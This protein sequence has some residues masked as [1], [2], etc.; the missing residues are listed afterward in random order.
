MYQ[1]KETNVATSAKGP[2]R[3]YHL[4]SRQSMQT[5]HSQGSQVMQVPAHT[6]KYVT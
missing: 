4:L 6:S 2:M 5:T 3:L 1:N